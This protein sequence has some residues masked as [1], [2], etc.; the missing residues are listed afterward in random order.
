MRKLVLAL[1]SL[2]AGDDVCPDAFNCARGIRPSVLIPASETGGLRDCERSL[3]T[4][5]MTGAIIEMCN[6]GTPRALP[7]AECG[8]SRIASL[9]VRGDNLVFTTGSAVKELNLETKAETELA[10]AYGIVTVKGR[11]FGETAAAF[12]TLILRGVRCRKVTW[13]DPTELRCESLDPTHIELTAACATVAT[14]GGVGG[15]ATTVDADLQQVQ[16]G[17]ENARPSVFNVTLTDAFALRPVALAVN[18]FIYFS[19][20]ASGGNR[21]LT[22]MLR[23]TPDASHVDFILRRAP[24][25]YGL[26]IHDNDLY[27]SDASRNLVARRP[28]D[29]L[30]G[31]PGD[32][33]ETVLA[34]NI[35]EPRSIA[36]D[37]LSS[38]LYLAADR[39]IL[40]LDLLQRSHPSVVEAVV[41]G[42]ARSMPGGII[43]EP[44]PPNT[45]LLGDRTRRLIWVDAN[46]DE[47]QAATRYGTRRIDLLVNHKKPS[48]E[49][50][51]LRF[52]RG[53]TR[54]S[55][56]AYY[57][58]EWLGGI[59]RISGH[60]RTLL[61]SDTETLAAP[62][63]RSALKQEDLDRKR[64]ETFERTYLT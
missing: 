56:D 49:D 38:Q 51:T 13:I 47:I 39:D 44:L 48:V 7:V 60:S 8:E 41:P 33:Y 43:L 19:S 59:W 37:L 21:T 61:R 9:A 2:A 45:S 28:A 1:A 25:I 27:Y 3:R 58:G 5:P 14:T 40:R 54:D 35:I 4:D 53:L 36:L 63:I 12:K 16:Y 34:E 42:Q 29:V 23:I 20:V 30:D 64:L 55:D 10:G 17:A 50:S 15:L 18:D 32:S 6:D 57:V 26:A 52:P 24:K 11:H 46:R 31:I 62:M 22:A